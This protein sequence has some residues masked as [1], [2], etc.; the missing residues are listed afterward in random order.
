MKNPESFLKEKQQQQEEQKQKQ[1]AQKTS[2]RQQRKQKNQQQH[3]QQQQQHIH[4]IAKIETKPQ[5]DVTTA[6]V[7]MDDDTGHSYTIS[8]SSSPDETTTM[9]TSEP[10]KSGGA[11]SSKRRTFLEKE[12][13]D[14]QDFV[15]ALTVGLLVGLSIIFGFMMGIVYSTEAIY[16]VHPIEKPKQPIKKQ[17][18]RQQ[19]QYRIN[20]TDNTPRSGPQS[21]R[22]QSETI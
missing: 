11:S 7:V 9:T 17:Q 15:L 1:P 12:I 21:T 14:C 20:K 18:Q 6:S 10:Q 3:Q 19:Q 13:I 2:K 4:T 16:A 8:N 5:S 22:I